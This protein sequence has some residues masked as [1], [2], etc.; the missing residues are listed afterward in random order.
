MT[1]MELIQT[2]LTISAPQKL[3]QGYSDVMKVLTATQ[4]LRLLLLTTAGFAS[5]CA[6][7]RPIDG[8]PARYLAPELRAQ[9]RS[10]GST[11]DL[12]LLAQK[13]PHQHIV[14]SQDVLGIYIE[15]VLGG[16]GEAP[17]INTPVA[18]DIA[19]SIGYPMS[20]RNDGTVSLPMIGTVNVRGMT[21]RQVEEHLRQIYTTERKILKE[22]ADTIIV[23]L[24]RPRQVRVLVLR[25]ETGGSGGAQFAQGLAVN[26]GQTKRGSGQVVNLP[27]YNNDVL[28]ALAQTGG[29]PGL[30]A[31]NTIY[32]IRRQHTGPTG[33]TPDHPHYPTLPTPALPQQRP[34]QQHPVMEGHVSSSYSQAN[35]NIQLVGYQPLTNDGSTV[36]QVTAYNT[37]TPQP[38]SIPTMGNNNQFQSPVYPNGNVPNIQNNRPANHFTI[39]PVV[40]SN[41]G[42]P[43][44]LAELRT[45]MAPANQEEFSEQV[46]LQREVTVEQTAATQFNQPGYSQPEYS[47]PILQQLP[48]QY[49][50]SEPSLNG[51]P[52]FPVENTPI[53]N[54]V[55]SPQMAPEV[56][57]DQAASHDQFWSQVDLGM[58]NF[59]A[60]P[61]MNNRKVIKIPIR[62]K[63]GEQPHIRPEDIILQDGDIVFIE[64]RDTEIFYTGG[65][66][67]GGQ[68]TLPRDYDL[69]VLDAISLAQGARQQQNV[70]NQIGGTSALNGDVTI[71]A[72]SVVIIRRMPNGAQVPIKVD[73][74]RALTDPSERILIQPGD[75]VMLRY[76]MHEAVGAFIERN[77]LSS[78]L[79]GLAFTQ[80]GGNGGN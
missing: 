73:L 34:T 21:I 47:Q 20:V 23:S 42:N 58:N 79:L 5:G 28:H 9:T 17:P 50:L 62:L 63:P 46:V 32:I 4:I 35:P 36:E 75:M 64:S 56:D 37:S 59:N 57:D 33:M 3:T 74:Y 6:A 41:F 49:R 24:Q 11:I 29:L 26:L 78:A 52:P 38:V 18:A 16:I 39:E 31:E 25:Q 65:L 8:V 53:N 55:A 51:Q 14:D 12:S 80:F 77:I 10:N 7:F 43:D 30:D 76:K 68:F 67:G 60:D 48:P 54:F 61:T 2:V 40:A 27:I 13:P 22:G 69:D 70:G 45:G 71:S 19:P 1:A 66:L 44:P 72:S 15:G